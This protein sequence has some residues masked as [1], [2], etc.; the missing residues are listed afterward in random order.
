VITTK[1][2][3]VDVV[4]VSYNSSDTLRDCLEPVAGVEG[5]NVFAIDNASPDDA[6]DVVADLDVERVQTGR[7]GG[8][9]FGC[10]VG[11][12]L[13]AAPYVLFLNP[14][15]WIEPAD[16]NVLVEALETDPCAGLVGPRLLDGEDQLIP[17]MRRFPSLKTAWSEALFV[18]RIV[19]GAS[20]AGEIVHGRE[21]YERVCFPDWVSGAAMLARREILESLGGLDEGFF[22]YSEDTDLCARIREAGYEIRYEPSA[23]VRHH[24]GRSAPR[25]SLLPVLAVSRARYANKHLGRG[26]T[27]VLQRLALIVHAATHAVAAVRR[28][29]V[30]RGHASA[31]RRLF[32]KV[33]VVDH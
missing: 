13:G 23:V 30:A 5:I 2:I 7:N 29:D 19:P 6:L 10:N 14:D 32:R 25:S 8:F 22:L 15:A 21:A 4:V 28:R 20:W 17:S 11:L 27:V 12:R 26:P 33:R 31:A 18:H 1:P 24:G 16:L 3:E 9:A